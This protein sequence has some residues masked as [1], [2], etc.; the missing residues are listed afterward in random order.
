MQKNKDQP[1]ENSLLHQALAENINRSYL[2]EMRRKAGLNVG[3]NSLS[4]A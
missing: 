3:T 1:P 2:A 4:E